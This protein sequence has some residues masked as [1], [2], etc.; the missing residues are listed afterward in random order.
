MSPEQQAAYI[1]AQTA[2]ML[3]EL[4]AMKAMNRERQMHDHSDAYGSDAFFELA[5]KFALSHNAVIAFFRD[6]R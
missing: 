5:D 1:N 4:E 3:A 6:G 2:C